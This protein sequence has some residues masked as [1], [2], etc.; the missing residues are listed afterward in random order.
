MPTSRPIRRSQ[1]GR[2]RGSPAF[3][4]ASRR[5]PTH[6][7]ATADDRAEGRGSGIRG[8]DLRVQPPLAR[9]AGRRVGRAAGPRGAL[10]CA[11][12]P[13]C[14]ADPREP[15]HALHDPLCRTPRSQEGSAGSDR[16]LPAAPRPGCRIPVLAR[17]RGSRTREDRARAQ[18]GGARRSGRAARRSVAQRGA[19]AV[20]GGSRGRAAERGSPGRTQRRDSDRVDGGDGGR[21]PGRLHAS[22]GH[23]GADR[24]RALGWPSS[25][26]S[27]GARRRARAGSIAILLV[28]L[29]SRERP[30][31]EC[32]SASIYDN[33]AALQRLFDAAP[34]M[35]CRSRRSR[36]ASRCRSSPARHGD[37]RRC[38]R[39]LVLARGRHGSPGPTLVSRSCSRC[40]PSGRDPSRGA[41]MRRRASAS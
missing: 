15:G 23:P 18:R 41:A 6:L 4:T 35:C 10:R 40:A 11:R 29:G 39:A 25:R 14:P 22:L 24:G 27:R 33:V 16:G 32:A 37:D 28:R 8:R 26:R 9:A 19:R 3:R 34:R 7:R 30:L 2:S 5:M 31:F 36:A 21:A 1:P 20:R 12:G 17:R 13:V 38:A